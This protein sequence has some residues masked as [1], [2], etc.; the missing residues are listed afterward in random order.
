M[1]VYLY[2]FVFV[3]VNMPYMDLHVCAGMYVSG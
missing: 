3:G 2:D 1:G